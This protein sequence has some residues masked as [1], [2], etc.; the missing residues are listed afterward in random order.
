MIVCAPS[1]FAEAIYD[2]VYLI[3]M[4][5]FELVSIPIIT[6]NE[7]K[8][9]TIQFKPNANPSSQ[10]SLVFN[11]SEGFGDW[12]TK[13]NHEIAN[14][15]GCFTFSVKKKG[16]RV[17]IISDI[18]TLL[19]IRDHFLKYPLITYKLVY[20]NIRCQVLDI[21]LAGDHLTVEGINRIICL[22]NFMKLGINQ[23][24][25]VDCYVLQTFEKPVYAPQLEKMTIEWVAGFV[26]TDWCFTLNLVKNSKYKTGYRVSPTIFFSQ[27]VISQ[28]VLEQIAILL[29]IGRL[30]LVGAVNCLSLKIIG[31][32]NLQSYI[33]LFNKT[34]LLE[35]KALDYRDFC[36]G[37]DI[38]ASGAHLTLT[39][40]RK[41]IK[42][43]NG[44]NSK[45][46]KFN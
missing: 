39:V 23:N 9:S 4:Y 32:T 13:F 35:T 3:C 28:I 17:F 40:I 12:L 1:I 41:L 25:Q 29:G 27:N 11:K 34:P 2:Q 44:M 6:L 7:H 16:V 37:L 45:R 31:L 24:L 33:A 14:G 26:N 10:Y 42:I 38:I 30:G 15:D 46:T 20:F 36:L 5:S 19:K 22:R 8:H 43:V 18:K 21:I